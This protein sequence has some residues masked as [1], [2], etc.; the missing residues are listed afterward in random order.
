MPI[1]MPIT[2][3]Q[4]QCHAGHIFKTGIPRTPHFHEESARFWHSL[5]NSGIKHIQNR[6]IIFIIIDCFYIALISAQ[7]QAHCAH[8]LCD[9]E[10]VTVSFYSAFFNSTKAVYWEHT[11]FDCSMAGA[12]LNCSHLHAP[13]VYSIL[14]CTSLQC[15][16]I[17]C[18]F[19]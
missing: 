2:G 1:S 3:S 6:E 10:W 16:F 19:V 4:R 5:D 13:F 8:N 18:M 17:W 14:P 7:Q 9:S 12:R 15:H 11:L